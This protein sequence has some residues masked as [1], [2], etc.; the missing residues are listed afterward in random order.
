VLAPSPPANRTTREKED[1]SDSNL[2]CW[3]EGERHSSR[4]EGGGTFLGIGGSSASVN[5]SIGGR[6]GGERSRLL[7]SEGKEKSFNHVLK[8]GGGR[9]KRGLSRHHEGRGEKEYRFY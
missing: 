1:G 4:K 6:R 7:S 8:T 5:D 2:G 3:K 9:G